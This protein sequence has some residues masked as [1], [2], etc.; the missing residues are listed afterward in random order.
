MADETAKLFPAD[1]IT[2][3]AILQV[4]SERLRIR[5]RIK[6]DGDSSA[7]FQTFRVTT[8]LVLLPSA[9]ECRDE[10]DAPGEIVISEHDETLYVDR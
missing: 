10:V 9:S 5:S 2:T 7:S 6:E 8:E 4:L 3:A 1:D